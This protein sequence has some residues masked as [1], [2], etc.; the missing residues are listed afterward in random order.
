MDSGECNQIDSEGGSEVLN[1]SQSAEILFGCGFTD[2]HLCSNV[3][4]FRKRDFQLISE[5]FL[6]SDFSVYVP[7]SS[8]SCRT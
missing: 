8:S 1:E 4:G 5:F 7:E 6:N 3:S 2:P